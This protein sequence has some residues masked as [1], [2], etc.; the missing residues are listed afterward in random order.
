[1]KTIFSVAVM[2]PEKPPSVRTQVLRSCHHRSRWLRDH[3]RR[4]GTRA[5]PCAQ[6][7]PASRIGVVVFVARAD[8]HHRD[9]RTHGLQKLGRRRV[10]AAV[11]GR[12][13]NCG[14]E[15][16]WLSRSHRSV[17]ASASAANRTPTLP[18]S[19]R[20]TTLLAFTSERVSVR[21]G[22]GGPAG[23]AAR[24][25]PGLWCARVRLTNRNALPVEQGQQSAVFLDLVWIGRV[26]EHAR[27][28]LSTTARRPPR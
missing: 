21:G 1:M 17:C 19:T 13:E 15:V 14:A 7:A 3:R 11:V 27:A 8:T 4:C 12:L 18:K 16:A 2:A 26:Q 22:A 20:D 28:C 23:S 6:G 9:Q 5:R 10:G 25:R 24:P